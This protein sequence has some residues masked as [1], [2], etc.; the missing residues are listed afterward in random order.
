[1]TVRVTATDAEGTV[2]A[3]TTHDVTVTG[4]PGY[5]VWEFGP[6]FPGSHRSGA[7]GIN[8]NGTLLAIGG[9]DN[10][11]QR[12]TAVY[13]YDIVGDTWSTVAPLPEAVSNGATLLGADGLVYMIGGMTASGESD[14]VHVFNPATG[15]WQTVATMD[16]P[17][18]D[19]AL[20]LSDDGYIYAMGGANTNVVER[21]AT[22]ATG[23]APIADDDFANAVEDTPLLIDLLANDSDPDGDLLTIESL[24]TLQTAGS[25]LIHGDG[26]VTYTPATDFEGSDTFSY[27]VSDPSGRWAEATATVNVAADGMTAGDDTES[28]DE[29]SLLDVSLPGVLGNDSSTNTTSALSVLTA[30][31]TSA[32]G[33]TVSLSANGGFLYDPTGV[34]RLQA[35]AAADV[36]IDTFTYTATDGTGATETA[37]VSVTVTGVN[38][39]PIA[40]DDLAVAGY[41]IETVDYPGATSTRIVG[42]NNLGEVVGTYTDA[43]GGHIFTY[44]GASFVELADAR[45]TGVAPS[46]I[47]DAGVIVGGIPGTSNVG[48]FTGAKG[49]LYDGTTFTEAQYGVRDSS[50]AGINNRGLAVGSYSSPAQHGMVTAVGFTYDNGAVGTFQHPQHTYLRGTWLTDANDNG[51]LVGNYYPGFYSRSRGFIYDGA[52]Y[53]D[54]LFPG[55]NW[56]YATAV[57]N[58]G[59]VVGT[60]IH[61]DGADRFGYVFD[62]SNYEAFRYPASAGWT[63]LDDINDAGALAGSAGGHGFIARP[64]S[65]TNKDTVFVGRAISTLANDADVDLSD[66]LSFRAYHG[67]GGCGGCIGP[68][69]HLRRF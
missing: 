32:L 60:Q 66:N 5:Q 46:A 9:I 15:S 34:T 49:F 10:N 27:R 59:H 44:D 19:H 67:A 31:S 55:T 63:T 56:G 40:Q 6:A 39:A 45:L 8:W 33:A 61:S 13:S 20:T 12:Q 3:A 68:D 52:T 30:D 51:L 58:L 2:S 16:A 25:L 21:I 28:T 65:S 11:G 57:N 7:G 48:G 22:A 26:T 4:T 29:D 64:A 18:S 43:N 69:D 23:Q 42:I 35:L 54:V 37:T 62:G 53:K 1:M 50:L 24:N 36:V 41:A 17:R 47:N 14:R 38:D